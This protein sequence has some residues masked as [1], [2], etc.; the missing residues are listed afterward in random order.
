MNKIFIVGIVAIIVG[1]SIVAV[2]ASMD[3]KM[4]TDENKS[5][6]TGSSDSAQISAGEESESKGR[7]LTA[8]LTESIGLKTP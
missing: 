4:L 8:E 6:Q 5:L 7:V 3:S 1:V 2:S